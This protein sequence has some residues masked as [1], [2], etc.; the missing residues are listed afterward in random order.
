M[1]VQIVFDGHYE[2][3]FLKGLVEAS[4]IIDRQFTARAKFAHFC[5]LF[6]ALQRGRN[7]ASKKRALHHVNYALLESTSSPSLCTHSYILRK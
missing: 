5:V 4:P 1:A 2:C 7:A 6:T 3:V